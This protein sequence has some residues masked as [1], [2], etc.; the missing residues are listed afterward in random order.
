MYTH[1]LTHTWKRWL[2]ALVLLM[3]LAQLASS[4]H[5]HWGEHSVDDCGLFSQQ[6][7]TDDVIGTN[8]L[9]VHLNTNPV[10]IT[11]LL[12]EFLSQQS[13]RLI[14]IRAPPSLS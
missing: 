12:P 5:W 6:N 9:T 2:P 13:I 3:V 1:S 11:T 7:H 14:S 8:A 4:A 10:E